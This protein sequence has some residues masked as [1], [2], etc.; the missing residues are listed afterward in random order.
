MH[1]GAE[2]SQQNVDQKYLVNRTGSRRSAMR[3]NNRIINSRRSCRGQ[4]EE[5]VAMVTVTLFIQPNKIGVTLTQSMAQSRT[6][7]RH[8]FTYSPTVAD[9]DMLLSYVWTIM[10]NEITKSGTVLS[11]LLILLSELVNSTFI[12]ST[13]SVFA[14]NSSTELSPKRLKSGVM[15]SH[16]LIPSTRWNSATQEN[17]SRELR[18]NTRFLTVSTS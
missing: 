12:S 7:C 2:D 5:I 9:H 14:A 13:V 1:N 10:Q 18:M 17:T 16:C 8:M 4:K 11:K 6:N 15:W 3:V